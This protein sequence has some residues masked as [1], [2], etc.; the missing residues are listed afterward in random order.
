MRKRGKQKHQYWI[1][2][3]YPRRCGIICRPAWIKFLLLLSALS[4]INRHLSLLWSSLASREVRVRWDEI[5]LNAH[6]NMSQPESV[7]RVCTP[8]THITLVPTAET[9]VGGLP[10]LINSDTWGEVFPWLTV[11][12]CAIQWFVSALWHNWLAIRKLGRRYWI[13]IQKDWVSVSTGFHI[14][15]I[16]LST[17]LSLFRIY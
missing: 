2:F 5:S 15:F 6:K 17:C 7:G 13:T 14:S 3:E 4:T 11:I 9:R 16:C 12:D 10:S 1:L 8:N